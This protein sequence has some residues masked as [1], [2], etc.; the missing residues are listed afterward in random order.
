MA[1]AEAWMRD[2]PYSGMRTEIVTDADLAVL[3]TEL[4]RAA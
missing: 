3:P 4:R 2:N 1:S